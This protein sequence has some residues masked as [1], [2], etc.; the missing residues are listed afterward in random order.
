MSLGFFTAD[1][2]CNLNILPDKTVNLKRFYS[3]TEL[4]AHKSRISFAKKAANEL[5]HEA[6]CALKMAKD[7]HDDLEKCY[8]EAMD[9]EKINCIAT[10]LTERIWQSEWWSED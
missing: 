9:Y 5:L 2:L 6:V 1:K 3:L 7:I 10:T 4:S 8:V